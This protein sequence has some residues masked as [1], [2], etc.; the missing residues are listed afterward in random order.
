[1]GNHGKQLILMIRNI[2]WG[3]RWGLAFAAVYCLYAL[4]L[5]VARG[6]SHFERQDVTLP[7]L[8]AA[9]IFGGLLGGAIVGLLRPLTRSR[10]GSVFVGLSTAIPVAVGFRM[11]DAGVTAWDSGDLRT[12]L[13]FSLVLG[14]ICGLSAHA[15]FHDP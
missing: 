14:P 4:G 11:A 5:F 1:M 8:L 13:I 2:Y 6:S 12:V 9:Y 3:I 7:L 10:L 15:I